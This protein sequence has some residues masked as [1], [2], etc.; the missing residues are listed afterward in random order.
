MYARDGD[1][2]GDS[3][4]IDTEAHHNLVASNFLTHGGHDLVRTK[5]YS[6]I[7]QDNVLDNDWSDVMGEGLG[8]RNATIDG[9]RN[10]FQRNI[11]RGTK[12]SIDSPWN[13]AMK[14]EGRATSH[15][16]I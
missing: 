5:G 8:A 6:N 16:A 9:I 14:V 3:I 1:D 10:V 12:K 11:V 4:W 2:F 15:G 7:V 13:Q